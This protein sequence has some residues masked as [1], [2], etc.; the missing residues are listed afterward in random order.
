MLSFALMSSSYLFN[1]TSMHNALTPTP[2]ISHLTASRP[3]GFSRLRYGVGVALSS[4]MVGLMVSW[5]DVAKAQTSPPAP[6]AVTQAIAQI[7]AAANEQQLDDLLKFYSAG[8]SSA[9]GGTVDTLRETLSAL[10]QRF[11]DLAYTTTLNNWK[12]EG[13]AIVAETTTTLSGT[14]V[15]NRRPFR[16]NATITARQRFEGGQI[17][18]QEVLQEESQLTAGAQPPV[19]DIN[20]PQQVTVGEEFVFDAIVQEP[21]GDRFLL[22]AVLDE[23]VQAAAIADPSMINLEL[24]SAG[25]LFKVGEAPEEAQSRWISAVVVR[26]DGITIVTRR[27]RVVDAAN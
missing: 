8:F 5:A 19:L 25:G 17:V 10:W 20:I 16:L 12:Q 1:L 3:M 9:D 24:L 27:L 11:P 26:D 4:L 15:L 13:N 18:S 23:P 14:E 6:E 22:G 21:L 7:D 2:Q